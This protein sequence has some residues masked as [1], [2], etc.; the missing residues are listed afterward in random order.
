[1][2]DEGFVIAPQAATN[3]TSQ[4]AIRDAVVND[5]RS[6]QLTLDTSLPFF[7][8]LSDEDRA[9]I[10]GRG[11]DHLDVMRERGWDWQ[12]FCRTQTSEEIRQ[13]WE[14]QKGELTRDWKRRHREAL[15]SRGRRGGPGDPE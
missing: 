1:M 7:F 13:R 2:L 8:P 5:M 4:A 12:R 14:A 11:R 10:K 6:S 3:E 15:K 9:A